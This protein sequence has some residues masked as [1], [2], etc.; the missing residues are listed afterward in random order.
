MIK[1]SY[2]PLF[3]I[4]L[5]FII[6]PQELKSQIIRGKVIDAE[7]NLPIEFANIS[8]KGEYIGTISNSVGEFYLNTKGEHSNKKIVLSFIGYETKEYPIDGKFLEVKLAPVAIAIGEVIIRPDSTIFTL[9]ER[10]YKRIPDNYPKVPTLLQGFYRESVLNSSNDYLYIA[11]AIINSYKTSY[12]YNQSGQV[13]IVKS[14]KNVLPGIDSINNVKFYGGPFVAHSTDLVHKRNEIIKPQTFKKY[15][16]NFLGTIPYG[17]TELYKISF[18]SKETGGNKKLRGFFYIEAKSFAYVY[19]EFEIT[20][21]WIQVS[22]EV[23]YS[24]ASRKILYQEIN[25]KWTLKSIIGLQH[26]YNLN[27]K[28]NFLMKTEYVTN[29]VADSSVKPIPFDNQVQFGDIFTHL[30][31]NYEESYWNDYN[32]IKKDSS[33]VNSLVNQLNFESSKDFLESKFEYKLT[34][35]DKFLIIP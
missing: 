33:E 6:S 24:Y 8:I 13:E 10:A 29:S 18:E 17:S 3:F 11:E 32:I 35:M 15:T 16:Y 23:Q 30:A 31:P 21:N 19:F 7:T 22:P 20:G 14:R 25:N 26:A 4:I 27:T 2:L 12:K 9:L 1:N 28:K 5:S 34:P